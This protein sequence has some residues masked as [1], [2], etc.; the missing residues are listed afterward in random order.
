M[1]D[2][3]NIAALDK[4]LDVQPVGSVKWLE[5]WLQKILVLQVMARDKRLSNPS[6][7]GDTG[8]WVDAALSEAAPIL[9]QSVP[10]KNQ[11]AWLQ[12]IYAEMEVR[13][14]AFRRHEEDPDGYGSA[15]L[16]EVMKE[17]TQ[18]ASRL[19]SFKSDTGFLTVLIR[20]IFKKPCS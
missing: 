1:Q 10:Y 7:W 17:V 5:A 18:L 8:Y 20:K 9:L 2:L 3:P 4:I 13:L 19:K 16:Q 15:T 11:S 12:E 14:E 6:Y